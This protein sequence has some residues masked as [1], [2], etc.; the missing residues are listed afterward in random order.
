MIFIDGSKF[1]IGYCSLDAVITA[2]EGGLNGS[3]NPAYLVGLMVKTN[4][5]HSKGCANGSNNPAG[6]VGPQ[7]STIP[8]YFFS[9]SRWLKKKL[10][11]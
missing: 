9:W 8:L 6:L 7:S 3:G 4:K 10:W 5:V 2:G 1:L 11:P